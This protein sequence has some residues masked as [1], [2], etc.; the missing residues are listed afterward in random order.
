MK[1]FTRFKFSFVRSA[2]ILE[3]RPPMAKQSEVW[4]QE[5][6][7]RERFCQVFH[8]H[9]CYDSFISLHLHYVITALH[10]RVTFRSLD[11]TIECQ[12]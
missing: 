7:A 9:G 12:P 10:C 11:S 5:Q 1:L 6:G 8:R 3:P 4:I 2:F